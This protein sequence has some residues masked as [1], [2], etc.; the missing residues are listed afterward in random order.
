MLKL[1]IHDGEHAAG[2]FL[3]GCG[4]VRQLLAELKAVPDRSSASLL[5]EELALRCL[6]RGW[7]FSPADPLVHGCA[8]GAPIVEIHL[9]ARLPGTPLVSLHQPAR[10]GSPHRWLH[11]TLDGVVS[12]LRLPP[13]HERRP[14]NHG[15][16]GVGSIAA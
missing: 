12:R 7:G 16:P 3:D 15:T 2:L 13:L 11:G 6:K 9:D 8:A 14:R 4:G 5:L 10:D 1:V